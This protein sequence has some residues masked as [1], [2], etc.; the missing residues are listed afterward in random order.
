MS[1]LEYKINSCDKHTVLI[2]ASCQC[3]GNSHHGIYLNLL[4]I[5]CICVYCDLY[6][7]VQNSA[8]VTLLSS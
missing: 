7:Y 3:L 5:N 8:T 1:T 6:N 4:Y 2:L